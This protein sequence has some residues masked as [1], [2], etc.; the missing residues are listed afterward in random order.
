LYYLSVPDSIDLGT[1]RLTMSHSE[2]LSIGN[3]GL[4]AVFVSS[5]STDSADFSVTPSSAS[6][7]AGAK[8]N[9]IVIFAPTKA[10]PRMATVTIIHNGAPSPLHIVVHGI[11]VTPTLS[12]QISADS[13][14]FGHIVSSRTRIDS[15]TITNTGD[16]MLNVS[17]V[18]VDSVGFICSPDIFTLAPATSKAIRVT[19]A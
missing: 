11:G 4:S 17:S 5:I 14:D 16:G 3:S 13:I 6:I 12:A 18:S 10:G 1:T 15:V 7:P 8:R 2:T 19:F 9:F